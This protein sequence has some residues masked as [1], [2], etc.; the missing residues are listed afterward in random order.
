MISICFP[1]YACLQCLTRA[2]KSK[3]GTAVLSMYQFWLGGG[4]TLFG[5][6]C[7]ETQLHKE[8]I[9]HA[10]H[11]VQR[12]RC[13]A[14]GS[15]QRSRCASTTCLR[16]RTSRASSALPSWYERLSHTFLNHNACD[17][18]YML[19][20]ISRAHFSAAL[21]PRAGLQPAEHD[22]GHL[23]DAACAGRGAQ[24]RVLQHHDSVE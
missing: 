7:L 24:R 9:N 15:R 17:H 22:R 21:T 6:G 11:A 13:G 5:N 8:I 12:R 1:F 3:S 14:A 20:K 2:A 19:Q 4:G 10:S 23:R 18:E 16:T